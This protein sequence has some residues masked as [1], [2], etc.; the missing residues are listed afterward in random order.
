MNMTGLK[1]RLDPTSVTVSVVTHLHALKGADPEMEIARRLHLDLDGEPFHPAKVQLMRDEANGIVMWQAE[2]RGA[3][4]TVTVEAPLFPEG[5]GLSTVVTVFKD[6]RVL[7]EAMLDAA[8]PSATLGEKGNSPGAL[9]A[10]WR[11]IGEGVAHIFLGPDHVLF[12]LSLLLLRGTW[13][14]L[15]QITT[16][17]TL[18]HSVTLSLAVLGIITPSP[19]L[20]EPL[21]ALSIVAVAVANLWFSH[22]EGEA[23]P[24]DARPWL[25]LSFGL[26]HGFGFA[27]ALREVG[28]PHESL[29]W[30]LAGFNVGVELGQAAIIVA[31]A[32]AL[33][34]LVTFRPR[35]QRPLVVY[36]SLAVAVMGG[37]WFTQRLF[38]A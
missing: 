11:F 14:Q 28:L 35:V 23:P 25:A 24:L 13:K 38:M 1:V 26:I 12:L 17:F 21:I 20:V 15:L 34:W 8:H 2:H 31:V 29:G 22:R 16:A 9:G 18:A 10:L 30:A 4:K 19:R 33:A 36:G 7:D 5:T 32:P 27:G 37:F 6:G 3:A